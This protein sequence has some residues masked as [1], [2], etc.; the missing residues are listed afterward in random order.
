MQGCG[1]G[2]N[3]KGPSLEVPS[4]VLYEWGFE[5]MNPLNNLMKEDTSPLK[6]GIS[7]VTDP[8]NP[9]NKVMKVVLLPG[10]TRAEVMLMS[11]N[12]QKILFSYADAPF[13][14]TDKFGT[15]NQFS[16][17]CELWMS[18][19]IYL[20]SYANTTLLK[21]CLF[22]FGPVQNPAF[23]SGTGFLQLRVRN[24]T[25]NSGEQWNLRIFESNSLTPA[26]LKLPPEIGFTAQNTDAWE[27]FVIHIKY[28]SASDGVIE[29][30]KDGIR[31]IH[32]TGPNAI[33]ANR[34]RIKW[35][36]YAGIDASPMTCYFDD[37]KIG[38]SNCSFE[39]IS[40]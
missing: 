27:K 9:L 38:G 4:N 11:D 26:N 1:G 16:L 12:L 36:I 40:R 22:Q 30:W 19:R 17:G 8:L 35:G 24:P 23:S 21:P 14:Y 7:V 28:S 32:I 13:G 5:G 15:A 29:I 18:V 20:P 25:T 2:N 10:H 3:E 6:D 37:V 34:C 31:Y 33:E 39:E